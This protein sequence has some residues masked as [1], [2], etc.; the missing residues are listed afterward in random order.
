MKDYVLHMTAYSV[1]PHFPASPSPE[2]RA[3]GGLVLSPG[4]SLELCP[5]W[6]V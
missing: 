4:L 5:F 6:D 1:I 3:G 2:D